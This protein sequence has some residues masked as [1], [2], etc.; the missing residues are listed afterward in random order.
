MGQ[1]LPVDSA[2]DLG[3]FCFLVFFFFF[4]YISIH[5]VFLFTW[6]LQLK[7]QNWEVCGYN[8]IIITL[9]LWEEHL[10]STLL[11]ICSAFLFWLSYLSKWPFHSL[12]G[13]TVF[14]F[15][16]FFLVIFLFKMVPEH[17]TK[18]LSQYF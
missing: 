1:I 17:S 5:L 2:T 10:R 7:R 15:L 16:C 12:S 11:T 18:A 9:I 3:G 8:H 14:A 6:Q 4:S 13:C